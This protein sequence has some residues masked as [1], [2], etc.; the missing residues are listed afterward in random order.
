LHKDYKKHLPAGIE[1]NADLLRRLHWS[2]EPLSANRTLALLIRK[3]W[4]LITALQVY[5]PFSP[6]TPAFSLAPLIAKKN[7]RPH[8]CHTYLSFLGALTRATMIFEPT[9]I[10]KGPNKSRRKLHEI[11]ECEYRHIVK[12][13]PNKRYYSH[14]ER[15][16]MVSRRLKRQGYDISGKRL[17]TVLISLSRKSVKTR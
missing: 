11:A 13:Q 8:F 5:D 10:L 1:W 3:H 6:E 17:E 2:K 16:R 7:G 4:E 15:C 14:A 12:G 9:A